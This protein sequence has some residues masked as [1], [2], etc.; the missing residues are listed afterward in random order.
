MTMDGRDIGKEKSVVSFSP[1]DDESFA[2]GGRARRIS[3]LLCTSFLCGEG[4]TLTT[5]ML[6][7]VVVSIGGISRVE[8]VLYTFTYT[9]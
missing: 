5:M 9:Y 2:T 4:Q 8:Y 7:V 1:R 3:N 6:F